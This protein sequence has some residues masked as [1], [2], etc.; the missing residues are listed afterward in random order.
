MNFKHLSLIISR[1]QASIQAEKKLFETHRISHLV[2]RN[3][4]GKQ[5]L[6]KLAAARELGIK[7]I[8]IERPVI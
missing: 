3:S 7:V 5:G 2:C 1:P 4:G 8:M 6:V